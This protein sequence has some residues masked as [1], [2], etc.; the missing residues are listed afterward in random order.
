MGVLVLPVYVRVSANKIFIQLLVWIWQRDGPDVE[1]GHVEASSVTLP[2][3]ADVIHLMQPW[4]CASIYLEQFEQR[5]TANNSSVS[6]P[7]RHLFF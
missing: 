2:A 7:K 4:F 6:Q 3:G 1:K 5:A